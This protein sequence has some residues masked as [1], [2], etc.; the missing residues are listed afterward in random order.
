MNNDTI[1]AQMRQIARDLL[2]SGQVTQVIGWE[3]GTLWYQAT[4]VLIQKPEDA[5]KLVWNDYC[6]PNLSKYL[7]DFRYGDGKTAIFVKGC[8]AR[9]FNRLLQDQQLERE[10]ACLIGIPC[11]GMKDHRIAQ[12]YEADSEAIPLAKIC[13][14]CRYPN[15]I[16]YDQLIGEEATPWQTEADYSDVAAIE[17]MSA[18]ERYAFWQAQ[19]TKCIRCYACRNVCPAC[20]C[21][22]C[23]FDQSASG[24]SSK[25][26]SAAENQFYAMTRAM[27]VAGRCIECG[28]C[29]YVC[30]SEIPIMLMNKKLSQD[31]DLLFG[32]Y[33]AG[34]DIQS[35]T[36]L[37]HF[38]KNDPEEFM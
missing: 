13:Q 28:Q 26:I 32:Q 37:G 15:P 16:V 17:A 31:I 22:K 11:S 24:W 36:P 27:H 14:A 12:G 33:D 18:D 3:Q 30:P 19:H 23:L 21:R 38:E 9:G 2:T 4:P 34:I 20:N 6:Q 25:D 35:P 10:K 1:Q 29:E 5:D 7:L 8:D